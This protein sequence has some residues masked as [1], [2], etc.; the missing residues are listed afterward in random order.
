M[1]LNSYTLLAGFVAVLRLVGGLLMILGVAAW[2]C[3]RR[4]ALDRDRVDDRFYLLLLLV[5]L[6]LGLNLL[7]WPILYLLLESYVPEFPGV[8]CIYGVTRVGAGST[9]PARHLPG[10]LAFL[11]LAKPALVFV[12]GAW[13]SLYALNR[14]CNTSP[15]LPRLLVLLGP[16]GLLTIADAGAELAY[17]SIP[18]TED[19]PAAGCCVATE[20][21]PD[22]YAPKVLSADSDRDRLTIAFYGG[23]GALVLAMWAAGQRL[24][25]ASSRV[26]ALLCAA[27]GGVSVIAG[28]FAQDVAAP[29]LLGLPDHH[30][31]Y[32]LLPRVPEAVVAATLFLAGGFSLGWAWLTARV[33]RHPETAPHLPGAVNRLRRFALWCYL[34]SVPMTAVE[35]ALA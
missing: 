2:W 8:M 12:G 29:K 28:V 6:V 7:S 25:G 19:V 11:Q 10:L 9:G 14:R 21:E 5:V 18:K 16:I 4:S 33:G 22:R 35:L 3:R 15:L 20:V 34:V 27:A 13:F 30:C 26:L 17:L 24:G 31:V 23:S 1:I 32:D